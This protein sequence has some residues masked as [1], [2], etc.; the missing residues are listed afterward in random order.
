MIEAREHELE[1][2]RDGRLKAAKRTGSTAET[3]RDAF[4]KYIRLFYDLR[5]IDVSFVCSF[6]VA[7]LYSP[8]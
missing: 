7:E 1:K 3:K 2:I 5:K 6:C 8:R 4:D